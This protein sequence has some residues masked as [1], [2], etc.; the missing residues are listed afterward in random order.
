MSTEKKTSA[1]DPVVQMVELLKGIQAELQGLRG[2]LNARIDQTNARM[3]ARFDKVDA[4]IDTGFARMDAVIT[5]AQ[6]SILTEVQGL[7]GEAYK[8]LGDHEKR[9]G[10]LEATRRPRGQA[11]RR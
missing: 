11:A 1:P 4:R 6:T 7:R 8:D 2:D 10:K 9:I 5:T 3:D